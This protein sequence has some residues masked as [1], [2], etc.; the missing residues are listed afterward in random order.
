MRSHAAP[1]AAGLL[2]CA[3]QLIPIAGAGPRHLVMLNMSVTLDHVAGNRAELKA[4]KVGH[5]DRV[6]IVSMP[7]EKN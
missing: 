7:S 4:V 6:R 5:V 1:H 2:L 3:L